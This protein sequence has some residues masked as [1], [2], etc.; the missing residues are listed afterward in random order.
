MVYV[1]RYAFTAAKR[2]ANLKT[3]LGIRRAEAGENSKEPI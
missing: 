1:G 2:R 3:C